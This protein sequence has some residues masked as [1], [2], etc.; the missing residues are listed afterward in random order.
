MDLL[1]LARAVLVRLGQLALLLVA[2]AVAT[3]ALLSAS[4]VDPVRA[5]VGAEVTAVGPEQRTQIEERWGLDEPPVQ[6]FAAWAGQVAQGNF[7]ESHVYGLP[8]TE[9]VGSRLV[10]SLGLMAGAWVLS[11]VLGF[12]LGALAG[13][14]RGTVVDR[15]ITWWAYALSSAP[16]FW[17]GLLL[18][19]VFSVWLQWTPVCCAGPVGVP[20]ADVTVWQRLH[21]MALPMLTLSVIGVGPITL[22]TRQAVVEVLAQDHVVMARSLGES[23]RGV[24]LRRVLRNAAA[25]AVMLQFASI[26]ELFG[27]SVLAEQ[28]FSYP[29]LGQATTQA[30]LRQDVPLLLAIALVTAVLVF[31]GNLVGDLVQRRLDPRVA[32]GAGRREVPA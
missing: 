3:F 24:L 19:Y 23:P 18:L 11:G 20:D 22:H 28:V 14:R 4:P 30:A 29:G 17:V 21:H 12:A 13:S 26:G 5:Y 10:A 15:G 9:V 31:C 2:V 6:R 16:T 1:S 27:G 7:G 25:P 8:V 32:V